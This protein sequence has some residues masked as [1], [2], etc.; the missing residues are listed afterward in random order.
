MI[1]ILYYLIS[2]IISY[3]SIKFCME[4]L[5]KEQNNWG[6]ITG[7]MVWSLLGPIAI[8]IIIIYIISQSKIKILKDPPKWL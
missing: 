4:K 8:L 2:Y 6:N 5:D 7:R 3:Y 1:W